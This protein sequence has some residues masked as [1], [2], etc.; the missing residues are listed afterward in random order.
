MSRRKF[1]QKFKE[2]AVKQLEQDCRREAVGLFQRRD[3]SQP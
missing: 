2:S 1:T 3:R